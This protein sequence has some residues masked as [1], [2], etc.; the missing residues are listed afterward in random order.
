MM[1]N[2]ETGRAIRSDFCPNSLEFIAL[3]RE[4]MSPRNPFSK[5]ASSQKVEKKYAF[6]SLNVRHTEGGFQ[7]KVAM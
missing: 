6:L 1:L 5:S 3:L 7:D 4:S 2:I